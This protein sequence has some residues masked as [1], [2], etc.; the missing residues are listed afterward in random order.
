M[1]NAERRPNLATAALSPRQPH[2]RPHRSQPARHP[3]C[4]RGRPINPRAL[5]GSEHGGARRPGH[6]QHGPRVLYVP[7]RVSAAPGRRA[8]ASVAG[9][10]ARPPPHALTAHPLRPFRRGPPARHARWN[11]VGRGLP[12][13]DAV[14]DARGHQAEPAGD[15][16]RR[17]PGERGAR[18]AGGAAGEGHPQAGARVRVPA[19]QRGGAAVHVPRLHHVRVHDRQRDAP[20]QRHPLRARR[21]RAHRAVPPPGHVRGSDHARHPHLRQLPARLRRPVPDR[22]HRHAGRAVL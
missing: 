15:G 9:V 13:P 10:S 19:R 4:T 7:R 14:R 22:A 3:H 2:H 18:D 20:P 5:S 16:L 21:P 11:P 6:F 8:P 12:P 17:V 1:V